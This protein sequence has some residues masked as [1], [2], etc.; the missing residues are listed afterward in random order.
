MPDEGMRKASHIGLW[1][2]MFLIGG[3]LVWQ[4]THTNT[5]NNS[6]AKGSASYGINNTYYPLSSL[7]PCGA[8]F[9]ISNDPMKKEPAKVV[10]TKT[11]VQK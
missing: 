10:T 5:E 1:I 3:W 8:F 11:E 6:Y 7:I 2:L 4:A 9:R